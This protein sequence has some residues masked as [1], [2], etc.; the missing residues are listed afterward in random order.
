[1]KIAAWT[2]SEPS[3]SEAKSLSRL[4][5]WL[6]W[7]SRGSVGLGASGGWATNCQSRVTAPTSILPRWSSPTGTA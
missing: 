4:R 5:K 3:R 7:A 2:A 6:P 1:M